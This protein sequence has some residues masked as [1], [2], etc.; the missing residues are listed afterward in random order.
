MDSDQILDGLKQTL[1]LE[2]DIEVIVESLLNHAMQIMKS[3][4][5]SV[6]LLDKKNSRLILIG[7]KNFQPESE[8]FW[9][10]VYTGCGATCGEALKNQ[11]R[12]KVSDVDEVE[13]IKGT[14]D[15]HSFHFSGI[16]SC[17]STPL[18]STEGEFVGMISTHWRT[19]HNFANDDFKCFD[20]LAGF[21]ADILKQ[22]ESSIAIP[23]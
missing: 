17:Q 23:V 20:L 12:V 3:D 16:K 6:Q 9:R 22:K 4:F 1:Q 11:A 8:H 18:I 7:Q 14:G 2:N 15:L 13:F 19:T 5:A 10:I 21:A